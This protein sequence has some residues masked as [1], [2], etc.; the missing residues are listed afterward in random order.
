MYLTSETST[1]LSMG[2]GEGSE[3]SGD[4]ST[5]IASGSTNVFGTRGLGS[6]FDILAAFARALALG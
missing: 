2:E 1:D 3:G 5:T 6:D 4:D